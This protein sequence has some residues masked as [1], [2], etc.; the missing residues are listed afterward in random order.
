MLSGVSWNAQ[1]R[2]SALGHQNYIELLFTTKVY[3][4]LESI[5]TSEHINTTTKLKIHYIIT[6]SMPEKSLIF[7]GLG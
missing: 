7:S 3:H 5:A 1:S 4:F 2:P 6:I